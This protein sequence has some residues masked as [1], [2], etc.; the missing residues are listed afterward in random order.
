[1]LQRSPI[2]FFRRFTRFTGGHLKVWHY[3]GHVRS[4]RQFEPWIYFAPGSRMDDTNPWNRAKDRIITRWPPAD[5]VTLF[6][7]GRDWEALEE[8]RRADARFPIINL[9]QGV[10]HASVADKR[11]EFLSRRAIRICVSDFVAGAIRKTGRVNGP[12]FT[13]RNGQDL[14]ELPSVVPFSLRKF[15]LCIVAMKSRLM[16]ES[17]S[18]L[19]EDNFPGRLQT[20]VIPKFL[21]R[22]AFLEI[23]GQSRVAIFLPRH[24]EGFYLPALEAMALQTLCICPDVGGNREFC[25]PEETCIMPAYE[26]PELLGAVERCVKM[27]EQDKSVMCRQASKVCAGHTLD[28]ERIR[29]VN[30]LDNLN[31]IW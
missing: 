15:D 22:R 17:L 6:L 27:S 16:G 1:M 11:Y 24:T 29:F 9:I 25:V 31:E 19:I 30:I 26:L 7:G 18:K 8:K 28:D 10:G 13:I 14:D 21:P 4:S 2:V 3:F 12:V 23:L 20:M 5:D